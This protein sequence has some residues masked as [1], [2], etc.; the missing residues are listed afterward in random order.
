MREL[1]V[2]G[3]GFLTAIICVQTMLGNSFRV[4][5]AAL[6]AFVINFVGAL[7][8]FAVFLA[9]HEKKPSRTKL[10]GAGAIALVL[11]AAA[12]AFIVQTRFWIYVYD[13]AI[14]GAAWLVVGLGAAWL[15]AAHRRV[16]AG[17][18]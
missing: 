9:R 18:R 6:A 17:A 15:W 3:Y 16:R 4:G 11:V 1:L 2:F 12:F 8:F 7:I 13:G 10:I 14:P 5:A